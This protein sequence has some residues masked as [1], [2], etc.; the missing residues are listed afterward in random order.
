[1]SREHRDSMPSGSGNLGGRPRLQPPGPDS[2]GH[3]DEL[4]DAAW[5]YAWSAEALCPARERLG[6]RVISDR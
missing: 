1:M 2:D 3:E 4:A 5:L 6:E